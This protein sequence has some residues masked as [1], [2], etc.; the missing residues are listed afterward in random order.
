LTF[1]FHDASTAPDVALTAATFDRATLLTLR[2]APPAT[3]FEPHAA[4]AATVPLARGLHD[5]SVR[6]ASKEASRARAEPAMV[7]NA[8]PA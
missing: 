6:V 3:T 1:G 5:V 4:S 2:K 7:E 8:P